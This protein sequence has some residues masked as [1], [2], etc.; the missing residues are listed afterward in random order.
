MANCRSVLIR[1]AYLSWG[2]TSPNIFGVRCGSFLGFRGPVRRM[3]GVFSSLC[4][5][6]GPLPSYGCLPISERVP[7][8]HV[9]WQG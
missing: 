1:G 6:W 5:V 4:S 2:D 3:N 8:L 9:V 7:R